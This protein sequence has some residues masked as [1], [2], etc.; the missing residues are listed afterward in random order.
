M[1]WFST[2]LRNANESNTFISL[3]AISFFI[4]VGFI[5]EL[6]VF[7]RWELFGLHVEIIKIVFLFLG[8]VLVQPEH[9]YLFNAVSFHI[10]RKGND[11]KSLFYS[12]FICCKEEACR[13]QIPQGFLPVPAVGLPP[14][15]ESQLPYTTQ[16]RSWSLNVVIAKHSLDFKGRESLQTWF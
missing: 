15:R 2:Y 14:F 6:P 13:W 4:L 12:Y 11:S 1:N 10:L 3:Q 8:Y 5:A 7:S 16:S 9:V